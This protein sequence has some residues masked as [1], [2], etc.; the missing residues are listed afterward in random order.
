MKTKRNEIRSFETALV[1][2]RH[3]TRKLRYFRFLFF[4]VNLLWSVAFCVNSDI[5]S[6]C[7]L[8]MIIKP[9]S[10]RPYILPVMFFFIRRATSELRQPI[11]VNLCH[12][13]AMCVFFIMQVQKFGGPS[14]PKKLGAKNMQNSARFQTTSNFDR[15]YLRNG[16]KYPKS[17]SNV[18]ISDSSRVP[19]EKSGELWSTNYRERYVS[20]NPPKL[21]F[22]GRGS[23]QK[24]LRA[25]M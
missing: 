22:L 1:T 7:Y 15:E 21:H 24:N 17:E 11:T 6:Y 14:P 20:L 2:D 25:N 23:P 9:P 3:R 13:I 5:D 4:F 16:T 12:M 8:I 18:M 19:L 10:G